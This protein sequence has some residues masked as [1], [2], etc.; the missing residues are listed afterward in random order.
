MFVP[1]YALLI[2]LFVPLTWESIC[3]VVLMIL[4]MLAGFLDDASKNPWGE[5]KKGII[6]LVISLAI[7]IVFI[8]N[9][10][11]SILLVYS[12]K[13]LVLP[14]WLY[15]VLGTVLVWASINV[16]LRRDGYVS[17]L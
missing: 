7:T 2:L 4:A 17:A 9:N 3:Y 14:F 5:Y 11:T 16:V 13:T 8:C 12:G 10:T 1:V 15:A 6:D